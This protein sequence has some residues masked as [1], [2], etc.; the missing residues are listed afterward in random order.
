[1]KKLLL[2]GM[3]LMGE[4]SA[5]AGTAPAGS[6]IFT[7]DGYKA[8]VLDDGTVAITWNYNSG[9]VTIPSE[10]TDN[11]EP[12][13][14]TYQVSAVGNGYTV[15]NENKITNLTI[16]EGIKSVGTSA[17]YGQSNIA[18]LNLPSTLTEIGDY[19]FQNCTGLASIHSAAT[20]VPSLGA[21]VFKTDVIGKD[22]DYIGKYCVLYV[23]QGAA[24]GY[25][26]GT[27]W[28]YWNAF[29]YVLEPATVTIGED[30]YATYF[31]WYGYQLPVGVTAYSVT[32]GAEGKVTLQQVY[33]EGVEVAKSTGLVLKGAPNE[34]Y[35]F[36]L[37]PFAT[38]EAPA[39]NLLKGL[40]NAGTITAEEGNY[41]YYKLAKGDKG[42]GFYWGA[43]EGGVFDL[44]ANKAYLALPQTAN[45][46]R[47]ISLSEISTGILNVKTSNAKANEIYTISGMKV[48]KSLSFL[49]KGIYIVNGKKVVRK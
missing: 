19:A 1:M 22:W 24:S 21:D 6:D 42:L 45:S 48:V 37:Q 8:I 3:M 35:I 7:K 13:T 14:G 11:A 16:S 25:K 12:S 9:D 38:A 40:H 46:A 26:E 27:P 41:N 39:G 4:F 23:P 20:S 32:Q 34:T 17:F 43:T 18:S 33:S 49:P 28:S 15:D 36:E 47:Y 5:W 31:N 2:F 44:A 10:V 29:W 30:G